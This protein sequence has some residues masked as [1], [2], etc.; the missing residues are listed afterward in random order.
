MA[1]IGAIGAIGANGAN[2]GAN[3]A[4]IGANGAK[5]RHV[6]PMHIGAHQQ[7]AIGA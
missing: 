7:S 5:Q 2:I 1:G 3:G 4:N 6:A